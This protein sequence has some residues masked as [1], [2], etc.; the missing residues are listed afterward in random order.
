MSSYT[1]SEIRAGMKVILEGDPYAI[2]DNE[3]VKPGKGQAFTRITGTAKLSN[4]GDGVVIGGLFGFIT[5]GVTIGGTTAAARNIIS[6]NGLNG[7]KRLNRAQRLNGLNDS[8]EVLCPKRKRR[9]H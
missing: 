6:G 5:N 9:R 1:T 3:F 8:L 7:A 2:V 4:L